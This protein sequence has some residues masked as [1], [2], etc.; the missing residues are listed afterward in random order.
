MRQSGV[1]AAAA[2]HALRHHRDRIADDHANAKR[3][4]ERVARIPRAQVDVANIE[5]NIVNVDL[6]APLLADAV[7]RKAR[8]VGLAIN[9]SAP[10]RLRAVTHLD[11]GAAQV[12]EAAEIL[13]KVIEQA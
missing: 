10:R 11:V 8:E 4:A 13:A 5:T 7:A 1:L 3:F 6:H 9:P 2:L 12:D